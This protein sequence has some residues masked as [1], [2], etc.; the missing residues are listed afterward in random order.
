MVQTTSYSPMLQMPCSRGQ[1]GEGMQ[2]VE[3]TYLVLLIIIATLTSCAS[4]TAVVTGT[5]RGAISPDQVRLY[6]NAPPSYETVAAIT[7]SS[8]MGWT[9]QG[10]QDYAIEELKEQA[11]E[12]GANGILLGQATER[13]TNIQGQYGPIPVVTQTVTGHAIYV[14]TTKQQR[15]TRPQTQVNQPQQ[16]QPS[17]TYKRKWSKPVE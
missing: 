3:A 16:P 8:N 11:A 2:R 13:R 5:K 10:S 17:G 14:F 12:L 6:S 9:A 15:K 1:E 4:G 7:A